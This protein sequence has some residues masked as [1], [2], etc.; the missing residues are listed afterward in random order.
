MRDRSTM[1]VA[2]VD[3]MACALAVA[4]HN[5]HVKTPPKAG[6]DEKAYYLLT[7]EW[8]ADKV[9]ADV[10]NWLVNPSRK[11]TFFGSRQKGCA[12]LD[13]DNKGRRDSLITLPDGSK[14]KIKAAKE[15]ISLRCIAPG[16]YDWG[17]NLYSSI[18][19]GGLVL[20]EK[21]SIQPVNVHAELVAV[22]PTVH[23]VWQGDVTLPRVGATVNLAS[24]DVGAAGALTL[25]PTS[26]TPVTAMVGGGAQ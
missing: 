9:D 6:V 8:D 12:T 1:W 19:D 23:L 13:V 3:L 7:V 16:H 21:D 5:M 11:A 25:T 2:L 26:L 4:M 10:D 17:V 20:S 22:E 14:A 18:S 24:F 15:T